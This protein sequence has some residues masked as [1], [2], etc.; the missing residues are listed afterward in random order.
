MQNNQ[1]KPRVA[2]ACGGTGGHLFPGLAVAEQLMRRGC[3]VSVL[4]SPKE[5][6]QQAIKTASGVEV[7]TLPAVG[8]VR[9]SRMAFVRGFVQSSRAARK[10]FKREK[11]EAVLAMGGFTSAPPVV[12]ARAMGIPTFLHE[13][14]M[15]PGR[16]N[17]WLSWLVHQAFIG[18]PGAAA[19]LHSRNVKV[20]G[21]PVRPQFLPGDL[22]AAKIALG[23][24][25]EKP[26]LLVTGGSQGASGLNDM[27]LGV[28]PLLLQQIPDLQLF[29][30]TGPTDVEK[31]ER[32]CV[33]LGIK[34]V[35]RP[36]FG[37]MSLA[38]GAASVAVSRAGASSL[39][40]LAAM[41]L[42]AVL[43]PF[44]AAT[45]NHQYFNALAFQETG[46]AHLLEQK[47][48]TPEIL[49]SLVIQL[50]QQ[51]AAREKMQSALDGWHAPKAAQ[52]IAESIMD[53]VMNRR[54][55]GSKNPFSE[56][57]TIQHHQSAI[58]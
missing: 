49:S 16:A 1:Q 36:F 28:L 34:A 37:E 20:T 48:A 45:D 5:V 42:P 4:I 29:H 18:F 54:R 3:T 55:A 50:I 40:E 35:V 32:A 39:A 10:L 57:P 31:V 24:S 56:T 38:L 26:L 11:P 13:S 27:V 53:K 52:V 41:R 30:L 9:G 22:A 12:A 8:L 14:N 25:P 47:Q 21:T 15:I 43:V 17:R 58:S 33:A 6:D 44:P 7:A 2:I 23:F 51:S 19:R 46:A